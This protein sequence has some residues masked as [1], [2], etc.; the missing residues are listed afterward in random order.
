MR[1]EEN[2][3]YACIQSILAQKHQNFE[4]I[5]VD[6]FSKD[7]SVSLVQSFNNE[8]IRIIQLSQTLGAEFRQQANKKRGI[9]LAVEQA[10]S[11]TI[12]MTDADCVVP[13]NWI[14][15]YLSAFENQD[16]QYISS[17]VYGINE[18]ARFIKTFAE[19]ELWA[20]LGITVSS[21]FKRHK[22]M[23][24][25][26]NMAFR[27]SAFQEVGGYL[28]LSK[29]ASGDDILLMNKIEKQFG[30]DA[31]EILNFREALVSTGL[32]E[33]MSTFMHQ[34]TRWASKSLAF[35]SPAPKLGMVFLGLFHLLLMGILIASA[36]HFPLFVLFIYSMSAKLLIDYLYLQKVTKEFNRTNLLIFLPLAEIVYLLYVPVVIVKVFAGTYQWK[37]RKVK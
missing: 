11:D 28:N 5:V 13:E 14:N 34:R 37:D 18:E 29:L 24:N 12:L 15:I 33:N 27:K 4:I 21:G 32:P 17:P 35:P 16:V 9:E 8:K 10:H 25:G 31:V 36:L 7:K 30:I 1:N 6:D 3:I 2:K 26:G 19:M 20:L 23:S 22:L